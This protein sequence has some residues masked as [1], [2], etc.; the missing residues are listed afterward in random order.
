MTVICTDGTRFV[1][2]FKPGQTWIK[3]RFKRT[4]V[5]VSNGRVRYSLVNK[6]ERE[7]SLDRFVKWVFSGAKLD[8]G[9]RIISCS[10][11]ERDLEIKQHINKCKCGLRVKVLH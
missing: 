10:I 2:K 8:V 5:D 9:K 7:T 1:G 6:K 3:G 11:C 4:L